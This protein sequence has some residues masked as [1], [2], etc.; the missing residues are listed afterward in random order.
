MLKSENQNEELSVNDDVVLDSPNRADI[1]QIQGNQL[2]KSQKIAVAVLAFFAILVFVFWLSQFKKNINSP[3]EYGSGYQDANQSQLADTENDEEI[4]KN[5]DTDGDSL[6]DWDEL[7]VYKTSP[8]LDDSD[9][10]GFSDGEEIKNDKD[11]NCPTGRDCSTQIPL[12]VSESEVPDAA[13]VATSSETVPAAAADEQAAKDILSG[14]G[15]AKALRELLAASGM[16]KT[17]LD[18]ISDEELM[19]FYEETLVSGQ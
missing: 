18:A 9:S 1:P 12:S 3:F 10:D 17:M 15:D 11:P 19:K 13:S 7:N 4:L 8:Y 6:K 14:Q 2:G 5:K 16:D